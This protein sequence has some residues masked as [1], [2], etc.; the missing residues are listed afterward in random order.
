MIESKLMASL[1]RFQYILLAALLA[2]LAFE[3]RS[4][5]ILSNLQ[6][7]FLALAVVSAPIIIRERRRLLKE[8]V[9]VAASVFLCVQWISALL[10]PDFTSN[11]VKGAVRVTAGFIILC[12]SLC[13]RGPG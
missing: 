13:A 2:T 4:V 3:F 12:A 6:W 7:L 5:W 1:D 10:A 9:V 8:R 11:A